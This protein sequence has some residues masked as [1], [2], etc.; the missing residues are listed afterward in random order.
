MI[1]IDAK[2]KKK[3]KVLR[4]SDCVRIMEQWL[5]RLFNRYK[6][7]KEH[8]GIRGKLLNILLCFKKWHWD[9]FSSECQQQ[10]IQCVYDSVIGEKV[11][12]VRAIACRVIGSLSTFLDDKQFC[13]T[14][15]QLLTQC[16]RNLLLHAYICIYIFALFVING[17]ESPV[18]GIKASLA[19]ANM[20][21]PCNASAA[22]ASASVHSSS[23]SNALWNAMNSLPP[24]LVP[25]T[26]SDIGVLVNASVESL[27]IDKDI[28]QYSKRKGYRR[29]DEPTILRVAKEFH[30]DWGDYE[31]LPV[32]KSIELLLTKQCM[33][34]I[35]QICCDILTTKRLFILQQNQSRNK[36]VKSDNTLD[37][38][39]A[40]RIMKSD[41]ICQVL[42]I[43]GYIGH[44]MRL[45]RNDESVDN[46]KK[47]EKE[48]DNEPQWCRI[49]QTISEELLINTGRPKEQWSACCT[50]GLI[51][52]NSQLGDL[53]SKQS[54]QKT[55]KLF[56]DLYKIVD[57]DDN[58]KTRL[59]AVSA[60]MS[61]PTRAHYAFLFEQLFKCSFQ[62]LWNVE[63]LPANASGYMQH[64][65]KTLLK[66]KLALFMFHLLLLCRPKDVSRDKVRHTLINHWHTAIK[67]L[68]MMHSEAEKH[69]H[70]QTD[71]NKQQ[72]LETKHI[73]MV[74]N[75][76]VL[77]LGSCKAFTETKTKSA[78]Q[79]TQLTTELENI[80]KSLEQVK[81][82][83]FFEN[84]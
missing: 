4:L 46:E 71:K 59:C 14:S 57:E 24:T 58:C 75:K 54:L 48:N 81:Q 83:K 38:T 40:K 11:P 42:R 9:L 16:L 60:L 25:M 45:E 80:S 55:A 2:K 33:D 12:H 17:Q 79:V 23:P 1:A 49:C 66:Q 35:L 47:E 52:S 3:K 67:N 44:H 76:L 8:S 82:V 70:W 30:K 18:V 64:K 68:E 65:Y 69:A 74:Y 61:I 36:T 51:L 20:C 77:L 62:Q 37:I 72:K 28:G 34:E 53:Q 21:D 29:V 6:N 78:P 7:N 19:L 32:R 22:A 26:G 50:S 41:I 43:I 15:A 13:A 27:S 10:L 31:C 39:H 84:D 5:P 73:K 63:R 56:Y